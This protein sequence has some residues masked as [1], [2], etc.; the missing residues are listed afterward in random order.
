MQVQ[1]H[2]RIIFVLFD[3]FC[4]KVQN[5]LTLQGVPITRNVGVQDKQADLC[6]DH[7]HHQ[8][9]SLSIERIMMK[10]L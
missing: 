3:R 2:A 5:D 1:S 9:S 6:L 10:I 4:T 8:E 7:S